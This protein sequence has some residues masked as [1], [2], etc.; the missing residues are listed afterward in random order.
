MNRFFALTLAILL[1]GIIGCTSGEKSPKAVEEELSQP[2]INVPAQS[3]SIG[4][5]LKDNAAI[6]LKIDLQAFEMHAPDSQMIA[7]SQEPEISDIWE[8][9]KQYL[10]KPIVEAASAGMGILKNRVDVYYV[11]IP[12]NGVNPELVSDWILATES[13]VDANNLQSIFTEKIAPLLGEK[14][15]PVTGTT[16]IGSYG[17][18]GHED[19]GLFY[20]C[21]G[22][23]LLFSRNLKLL[24]SLSGPVM[25]TTAPER[26]TAYKSVES[27][28]RDAPISAFIDLEAIIPESGPR[29]RREAQDMTNIQK[30]ALQWN[31]KG[32]DYVTGSY[33]WDKGLTKMNLFWHSA[34]TESVTVEVNPFA[35]Q[36]FL[37]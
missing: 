5:I 16:S 30:I 17:G 7:F 24:N 37:D 28:L 32:Y 6:H 8:E 33:L 12:A 29:I 3:K 35:R 10:L 14:I 9:T 2:E 15:D 36:L 26:L 22:N 13:D 11:E 23:E 19:E 18:I 34:D 1:F 20:L 4:E 21:S 31:Q 27:E 25:D